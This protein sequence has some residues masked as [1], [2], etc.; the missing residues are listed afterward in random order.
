[1][2]KCHTVPVTPFTQNCSILWCDETK[3]AAVVDPGCDLPRLLVEI[4]RLG[5]TLK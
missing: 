4:M 3:E 2:L 1:M 5:L